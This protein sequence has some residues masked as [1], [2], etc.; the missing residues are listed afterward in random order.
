M[1]RDSYESFEFLKNE[2]PNNGGATIF[3]PGRTTF[4]VN[5]SSLDSL[6]NALDV[7][8]SIM[9]SESNTIQDEEMERKRDK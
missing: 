1:V 9:I 5:K 6:D 4:T 3:K 8:N 2:N 7:Q